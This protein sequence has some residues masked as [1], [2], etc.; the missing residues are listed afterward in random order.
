[1]VLCFLFF[2]SQRMIMDGNSCTLHIPPI[3]YAKKAMKVKGWKDKRLKFEVEKTSIIRNRYSCLQLKMETEK[4]LPEKN[5]AVKQVKSLIC[6]ACDVVSSS[7]CW[8]DSLGRLCCLMVVRERERVQQKKYGRAMWNCMKHRKKMEL[9]S[10]L[11][12]F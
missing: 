6:A 10:C 11:D 9:F 2:C 3:P 8:H 4:E 7:G 1:M 5:S 12:Q